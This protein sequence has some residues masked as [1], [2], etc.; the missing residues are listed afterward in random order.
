MDLKAI[1]SI[2]IEMLTDTHVS[3][4]KIL[5]MLLSL[6]L[7]NGLDSYRR[8]NGFN[9][10]TT[11]H[12]A[13]KTLKETKPLELNSKNT[14]WFKSD[15]EIPLEIKT[16]AV[17]FAC[18]QLRKNILVSTPITMETTPSIWNHLLYF[19]WK[20]DQHLAIKPLESS[21]EELSRIFLGFQV[22][23]RRRHRCIVFH[24]PMELTMEQMNL[25]IQSMEEGVETTDA[26]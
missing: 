21:L 8:T 10:E 12:E 1:N 2:L 11:I 24:T 13:I 18:R 6:P 22:Q 19:H 23:P 9:L 4:T 3:P 16:E 14:L 26:R 7:G 15:L 5:K 20:E 17:G 25:V